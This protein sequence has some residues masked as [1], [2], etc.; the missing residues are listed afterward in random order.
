M[1]LSVERRIRWGRIFGS[2]KTS[3]KQIGWT[4]E[5]SFCA[6]NPLSGLFAT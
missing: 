6:T 4:L 1:L 2:D 3:R 5:L